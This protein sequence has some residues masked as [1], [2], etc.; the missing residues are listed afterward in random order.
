MRLT[1]LPRTLAVVGGRHRHRVR[2]DVRRPRDQVTLVDKRQRPL[3]FLDR[4]IVDEL[5]HQLRKRKV[6]FRFGET[7]EPIG[8]LGRLPAARDLQLESANASFPTWS[9]FRRAGSA[10][11]DRLNLAAAGSRPMIA[12]G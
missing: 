3:E 11:R 1:Q 7:V 2:V 4:E 9:S 5:M 6:T 8:V 10:R 12:A